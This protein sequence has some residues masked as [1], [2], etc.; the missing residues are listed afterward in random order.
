MGIPYTRLKSTDLD[1]LMKAREKAAEQNRQSFIS[2]IFTSNNAMQR[3]SIMVLL[4]SFA[5]KPR[6]GKNK[7]VLQYWVQFK[8]SKRELYE[9]FQVVLAVPVTQVSV[10]KA[11]AG[12]KYILSALRTTHVG[13][14]FGRYTT[15][16]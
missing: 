8:K 1:I 13:T 3:N 6:L 9:L 10:E 15:D 2:V 11:F 4:N 16:T 12:L 14:T 5:N 7:N